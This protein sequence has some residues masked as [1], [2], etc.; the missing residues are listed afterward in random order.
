M[1]CGNGCGCGTGQGAAGRGVMMVVALAAGLAAAGGLVVGV[2]EPA[3]PPAAGLVAPAEQRGAGGSG[4]TGGT[5][6]PAAAPVAEAPAA[7][8][9]GLGPVKIM[10]GPVDPASV[11]FGQPQARARTAGAIRLATY[12]VE[13]LFDDKDDPALTGRNDDAAMTKPEPAQAAV[14]AALRAVDADIVAL[15]EVESLEALVWFRD[16]H[17]SGMGYEHVVS[18]DTGD[19]R[20]I[21]N[22]VL[23][24]FPLKDVKVWPGLALGGVH[25]AG[26]DEAAQK[27]AGQPLAFKR[28]PLRVTATVPAARAADAGNAEAATDYE[29][30][31]FV[32]HQ[33]SG[34]RATAYWRDAEARKTAE[35]AR[36]FAAAKPGAN[37]V[38]LGDFNAEAKH[39][40]VQAYLAGGMVDLFAGRPERDPGTTSHASGRKIDFLLFNADAMREVVLESRFVLGTPNRP[41]GADWRTTPAPAG[42]ASDHYPVVVDIRPV[43]QK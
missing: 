24:R 25:P 37:V 27:L 34:G 8:A 42:W 2:W 19:D 21:E 12:N 22:A 7:A 28:S 3:R 36:E 40:G 32:V 39:E 15:Q 41:E 14:A 17:L 31:L 30:T 4:G 5:A 13:N 35:L 18:V 33:K 23:S 1:G 11:R 20:G 29:L 6:A 10:D 43:D 38:I 9:D 26:R 16:R